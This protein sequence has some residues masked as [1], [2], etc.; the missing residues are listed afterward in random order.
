MKVAILCLWSLF[1]ACGSVRAQAQDL[2]FA[3]IDVSVSNPPIAFKAD[4]RWNLVY[5]LRITSFA[6]IGDT[7]ITRVDVLDSQRKTLYG[8]AGDD[9]KAS[10]DPSVAIGLKLGPRT[11]TTVYMWIT[12]SSLDDLPAG[13]RHRV[14]VKYSDPDS[15]DPEVAST[16]TPV[17]PV[18]RKPVIVIS[19]P[20]RGDGWMA[21]NGPSPTSV[22]RRAILPLEGHAVISQ[23]FAIDWAQVHPDGEWYRGDPLNN[24]SYRSYGQMAYAV[25]DGAITE[26]KDGIPENTPGPTS[27][28]VE[29]TLETMP[30]NHIIEQIGDGAYATYAHLQPGSLRVKVG[31]HVRPGQVLG[32]LGNSGNSTAPHLHFQICN[33][34]S[35]MACEGLPYAF[36]SFEVAGRW[37]PGDSISK[38]EMEIP[39]EGEVVNF[40]PT[41]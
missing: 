32:L 16:E 29:M 13:L 5:E 31:D 34:N 9:L 11:F 35:M 8:L 27:R 28:A 19:P 39:T 2:S 22:H 18:D 1:L 15:K 33:A 38:H 36:N 25:A 30:G 12:S 10:T 40:V 14:T 7:T 4:G 37:K 17:V 23:R 26:A 6:D 21:S 20:L 41:P 3:P 24:K